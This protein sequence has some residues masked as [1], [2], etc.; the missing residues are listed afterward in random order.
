MPLLLELR[1]GDKIYLMGKDGAIC[2]MAG[3]E[4]VG[5]NKMAIAFSFAE[6]VEILRA[7]LLKKIIRE[8]GKYTY[9]SMRKSNNDETIE[10]FQSLFKDQL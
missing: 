9:P 4:I 7:G 5:K 8:K 3:I 10:R 2:E 1:E 6:G